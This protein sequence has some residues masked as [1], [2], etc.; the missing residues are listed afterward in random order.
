M[1]LEG[2]RKEKA[3]RQACGMRPSVDSGGVVRFCLII[4]SVGVWVST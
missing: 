3:Q 2:I 1:E 4:L